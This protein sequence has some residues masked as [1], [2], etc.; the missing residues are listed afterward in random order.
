MK[1]DIKKDYAYDET[2]LN[3]EKVKEKLEDERKNKIG[4]IAQEVKD[5]L[6]EVVLY[7]DS[8]DMY[9]IDYS[10]IIPVLVEA[11]KEQN[12]MIQ[13][14]QIKV[15]E[16]DSDL[17]SAEED[18]SDIVNGEAF[19]EQNE[20]NPFNENTTIA[21]FLP[22]DIQSAT[23]YIYDMNGKQLKSIGIAERENGSIVIN[24]NELNPGMYYYSLIADGQV[25]GTKQMILTD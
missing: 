1:Y 18:F 15:K 9:G 12:E 14:L 20:P 11:I 4:F 6:P 2:L 8:A 23:F 5:I 10:K 13:D 16:K 22:S 25:I 3:D 19:L 24:A 21:Y 7:D 17:K